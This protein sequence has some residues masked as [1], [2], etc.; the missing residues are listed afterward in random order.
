MKQT[1]IAT[2]ALLLA[3]NVALGT[4]LGA[5]MKAYAAAETYGLHVGDTEITSEQ[6]IVKSKN[7]TAT[8]DPKTHTLTLNNYEYEGEG[9]DDQPN[10][11]GLGEGGGIDYR[12]DADLLIILKGS[13][14]I[15]K[16]ATSLLDYSHG[17]YFHGEGHTLTISGDGTLEISFAEATTPIKKKRNGIFCEPGAFVMKSGSVVTKGGYAN[18]SV[19][20][21]T[22][23]GITINGGTFTGIGN[24]TTNYASRGIYTLYNGIIINGGKVTAQAT[25]DTNAAWA[26][27]TP[28]TIN[29]GTVTA[30]ATSNTNVARAFSGSVTING[31]TVT[32]SASSNGDAKAFSDPFETSVAIEL[33]DMKVGDSKENATTTTNTGNV[34]EKKYVYIK[35]NEAEDITPHGQHYRLDLW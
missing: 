8:Y 25:D 14:S 16:S 12:G 7:G 30:Q 13:N 31:G 2:L 15:T 24:P 35:V 23:D 17:I 5:G 21:Y 27:G 22:Q 4:I 20:I 19:G 28:V 29:G 9:Y 3:L 33:L 10:Y 18:E 6:L 32:A 26:F 34:S 1:G 11:D